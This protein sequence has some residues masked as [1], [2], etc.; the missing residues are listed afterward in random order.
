[1]TII[2][3]TSNG[4][5]MAQPEN[6]YRMYLLLSS[7]EINPSWKR[8]ES[9]HPELPLISQNGDVV[10]EPGEYDCLRVKQSFSPTVGW[11]NKSDGDIITKM[12]YQE[13]EAYQIAPA[14]GEDKPVKAELKNCSESSFTNMSGMQLLNRGCD[15]EAQII[16]LGYVWNRDAYSYI[17]HNPD[18]SSY[19]IRQINLL[20]Y[21]DTEWNNLHK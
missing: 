7:D 4:K 5:G 12:I 14:Q 20:A 21:D 2:K 16:A 18:G 13:R 6:P 1:M 8:W 10:M 15:R 9:E 11:F 19:A 3:V 17:R